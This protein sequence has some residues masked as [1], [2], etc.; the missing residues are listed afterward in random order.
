MNDIEN[1][2]AALRRTRCCGFLTNDLKL[3]L[4]CASELDGLSL[5]KRRGLEREY[6]LLGTVKASKEPVSLLEWE[7]DLA[8]LECCIRPIDM[9]PGRE[10]A[11]WG[12]ANGGRDAHIAG[13]AGDQR[14]A[15]AYPIGASLNPKS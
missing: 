10:R 5:G 14:E 12:E 3:V 8:R 13:G 4:E 7:W 2:I 11:I 15:R 1:Y 9:P 6:A